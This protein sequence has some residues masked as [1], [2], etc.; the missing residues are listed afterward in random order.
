MIYSRTDSG[1]VLA[2]HGS[3]EAAVARELL[4]HDPDL[5]LERAIHP[6]TQTHFWK[7]LRYVGS[8]R[9]LEFICD[10]L[11]ADR[12]P[13][14]LSMRLLDRVK[15]HDRN[16]PMAT[17][18]EDTANARHRERLA[19]E[20]AARMQDIADDHRSRARRNRA[21]MFHKTPGYIKA[22]KKN[23]DQWWNK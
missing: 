4:R 7:V 14:P 5:R 15:M 8:E 1:L 19:K 22:R 6:D 18:D 11:D 21:P 10:W 2:E 9:P 16:S 23:R 20:H 12:N 3:D 13:L 17:L